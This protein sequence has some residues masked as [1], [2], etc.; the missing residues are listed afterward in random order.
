LAAGQSATLTYNATIAN[1]AVTGSNLVNTATVSGD[2]LGGTGGRTTGGTA[3]A[4]VPVAGT[5]ALAKVITATSEALTGTAAVRTGVTDLSVGETVTFELTATFSEGTTNSVVI[6]DLLPRN[7]GA[8]GVAGTLQYVAGSAAIVLGTGATTTVPGTLVQTDTNGDGI[9]DTLAFSFGTV[10]I[11]GDNNAANNFVRI[12]YQAVVLDRAENQSGD[13]LASPATLTSSLG[14]LNASVDLDVVAPSLALDKSVVSGTYAPGQTV[15]YTV[16]VTNSGTGPAYNLVFDDTLPTGLSYVSGSG[17]YTLAGTTTAINS[18]DLFT[19]PSL[20]P[21]Q[22]AVITYQAQVGT[23]A[24]GSSTLV[25]VIALTSG[26]TSTPGGGRTTTI[27]DDAQITTPAPTAGITKTIL[28]T[29][30]ALTGTAA[31]RAGV[32]D[33]AIGEGSNFE[34]VATF[35]DGVSQNVVITDRLPL[36]NGV[37]QL[38]GTPVITL[39]GGITTSLAGTPTFT[40]T[41]N[42][43]L[44]DTAVYNF[45]T[46]TVP[47]DGNLANNNIRISYNV[48]LPDRA[49]NA[50]GDRLNSPV[51]LTTASTTANAA[52]DVDVVEPNVAITKTVTPTTA[53]DAG[54]PRS[55]TITLSNSGTGPAADLVLTDVLPS[56]ITLVAG[57]ISLN[58][59]G[60]VS[61]PSSLTSVAVGTLLP[62][63]TA[64]LT[65]T[66]TI[67]ASA[68]A[69]STQTNTVTL[70]GDGL[71]GT[72]GR[73][74]GGSASASVPILATQ[75]FTKAVT[76]TSDPLTGDAVARAGVP[77]LT[78]GER[79]TIDLTATFVEGTTN[80][81]VVVDNLVT[82]AGTLQLYGTPT[83]ILNGATISV[84]FTTQ[85]VDSN[86]DGVVDQ[87]RFVLGNVTLPGDNNPANN[88]IVIRYQALLP[89]RTENQS[90]DQIDP[91]ATLTSALGTLTA[92]VQL[93]VVAPQLQITKAA[94]ATQPTDGN[95]RVF[96]IKVG[97]TTAS[98]AAAQNVVISDLVPAGAVLS[99]PLVMVSGP[100][101]A[102][103]S[104]NTLTLPALL[105]GQTITLT[106]TTRIDA[107]NPPTGDLTN[108]ARVTWDSGG[109]P[110]PAGSPAVTPRPGS[111]QAT[112][113]IP[114]VNPT[115]TPMS[116]MMPRP[117]VGWSWVDRRFVSTFPTIDPVYSGVGIPGSGVVIRVLDEK[118]MVTGYGSG[119]SDAGGNWLVRLPSTSTSRAFE[120][121]RSDLYYESTNLFSPP[122]GQ[123]FSRSSLLGFPGE[124]GRVDIGSVPA[125]GT[126]L[127]EVDIQPASAT[128]DGDGG[129]GF[130]QSFNPI[131]RGQLFAFNAGLSI[132]SI[133]DDR[134]ERAIEG[135]Y[136]GLAD[137]EEAGLNRFNREFLSAESLAG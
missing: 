28:S 107:A 43:G 126:Q 131:W 56:G 91:G 122:A 83:I 33:L 82:P 38:V 46:V 119:V 92:A 78:I 74:L 114:F 61:A 39:Q 85:Q 27:T 137:P 36:V 94:A 63:Q 136:E 66:G 71:P 64:T 7:V 51:T 127:V 50:A 21:G 81:V 45:G 97:H 105:T 37:L 65:Y 112:A 20:Q 100:A 109:G 58:A 101:G 70:T 113:T 121:G 106:A 69:G 110:V 41:D 1:S 80:N 35:G 25:N 8:A 68:V 90:G 133:F 102:T 128:G 75:A 2:S 5:Q 79:A 87:L 77:D 95:T 6:S 44:V 116:E 34:V 52:V 53:G 120:R 24:P 123:L 55:Y 73:P 26:T 104:G 76:A 11:P 15:P 12:T 40:D 19:L 124:V 93:D 16:T 86:G 84:P 134:A 10:V 117:V 14:T 22:T 29:T 129:M 115:T 31:D 9:A 48:I 17:S 42:D 132:G 98:N 32:V 60:T 96:T 67:A 103:I 13:Q 125:F 30:E 108:T 89:D 57:S 49:V 99:G 18:P 23:N 130:S 47:A 3:Q 135:L 72:G 4:T 54:D 59:A 88:N 111:A 118:G 62:G